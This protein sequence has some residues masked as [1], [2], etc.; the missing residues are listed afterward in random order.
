MAQRDGSRDFERIKASLRFR[1]NRIPDV[2]G[3]VVLVSI[4]DGSP[5]TGAPGQPVETGRLRGSWKLTRTASIIRVFTSLFYAPFIEEGQRIRHKAG[6]AAR[7]A[8]VFGLSMV[9]RATTITLRSPT[10]GFH[11]V[12]LTRAGI[13]RLTDDVVHRILQGL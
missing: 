4:R 7:R 8:Q 11:S 10:G 3:Q 6:A 2:L 13:Q 1:I 12:K 9:Q 5:L